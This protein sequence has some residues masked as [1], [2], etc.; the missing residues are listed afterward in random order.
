MRPVWRIL[1]AAALAAAAG[2]ALSP[3]LPAEAAKYV[4]KFAHNSPPKPDLLY[5]GTALHFQTLLRIYSRGEADIQI[6]PSSQLG[7][8][9]MAAKKV[10][11]GSVHMQLVA[12]NNISFFD[13]R[14]DVFTLPFLFDSFKGAARVFNGDIGHEVAEN[15]RKKSGV[16]ILGFAALGFRNMTNSRHPILRPQDLADLRMRIAKNPIMA[17]TYEVLGGSAIAMAPT[18]VVSALSTRA[19]DGQDGGSAWAWGQKLY[20]VQKYMSI[21]RHQLVVGAVI[22]NDKYFGGLPKEIQAAILKAAKESIEWANAYAEEEEENIIKGFASKGMKVDRP[23]LKP[24]RDAVKPVYAK[25]AGQLGGMAL[26]D[27]ILAAQR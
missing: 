18:E 16:R 1:A 21:T 11:R 7:R 14:L 10:K 17:S 26:I 6:F 15:F 19:V 8:D 23:D 3:A 27:K 20:E 22:I 2:P 9:A 24:F 13:P 5:Q 4:M 25:F 12:S